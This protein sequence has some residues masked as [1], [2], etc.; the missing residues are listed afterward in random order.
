[1]PAA[2][3]VAVAVGAAGAVVAN[4][5]AFLV[6]FVG[7]TEFSRLVWRP[8]PRGR[9]YTFVFGVVALAIGS[10]FFGPA[11]GPLLSIIWALSGVLALWVFRHEA[12]RLIQMIRPGTNG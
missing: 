5:L 1:M 7:R 8:L 2:A 3:A 11:L 9:M 4:A 6:F 12:L 10:V